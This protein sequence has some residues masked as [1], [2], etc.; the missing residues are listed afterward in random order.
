LESSATSAL[1]CF[2]DACASSFLFCAAGWA[3]STAYLVCL[4][5]AD[6]KAL[7]KLIIKQGWQTVLNLAS[8]QALKVS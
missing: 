2:T 7:F 8:F 4:R 6:I 3:Y 1:K 5:E